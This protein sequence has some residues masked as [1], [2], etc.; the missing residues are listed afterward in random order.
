MIH[1]IYPT[2][3]ATIY[4]YRKTL[5]SGL[6]SIVELS[7]IHQGSSVSGSSYNSR[8]LFKFD[9][10][11]VEQKIFDGEIT[12]ASY[13]L[14]LRTAEVREIPFEYTVYAYPLS[15]S[16]FSG[17]GRVNNSPIMTDGV[18][19]QYRTST[20]VGHEWSVF[21][22]ISEFEWDEISDSWVDAQLLFGT[23][24]NVYVTSSFCSTQ[25]GGT[26]WNYDGLECTQSFSYQTTDVYMNVDQIVRK[27]ITGSGRIHN[28]GMIM[29]FDNQTE[30]LVDSISSLKFFS[31]DSNTIYVPRLH[32]HWDD[33]SFNPTGSMEQIDISSANVYPNI[34][35]QYSRADKVRLDISARSKN[36]RKSYSTN[37]YYLKQYYLPSSS[38]Y[39][40]RDAKT[41]DVIIPMNKTS[42]KIS[43][44]ENGSY[45]M[46][47]MS[48]LQPERFY[49]V[50]IHAEDFGG[51]VTRTYDN[52]YMFKVAR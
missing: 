13:Y 22:S 30:K 6:D 20:R 29:M 34:K 48:G 21:P 35:S 9:L 39:E 12:S 2:F 40:I 7:H 47:W 15:G 4:E 41:D 45:F 14:S 51:T 26:W 17:T 32:V 19:W 28:D 27:W 31:S 50:L 23:N 18:S 33:S 11:D 46:L 25:G 37:S 10:D 24:L 1:T 52:N 16:W 8:I 5:N 44:D 36:P 49:R 3:D 38:Y 42:T 43:C